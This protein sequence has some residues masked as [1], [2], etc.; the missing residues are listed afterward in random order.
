LALGAIGVVFGDIGT[1]PLYA[2]RATLSFSATPSAEETVLG[3]LSIIIWGLLLIVGGKYISLLLRADNGGEGGLFALLAL[4]RSRDDTP[5]QG[6]GRWLLWLA[7]LG[8]ALLYGDGIITPA[9]SVLSAMGG[10]APVHGPEHAHW[11]VVASAFIV[12]GVFL[13]QRL[14]SGRIGWLVGP[15]ML[16]WFVLIAALGVR[17]I[18]DAPGVLRAFSPVW[19]VQLV[20]SSPGTAFA[21]LGGVV[22]CLTGAEALY[23]DMGHFGR[24]AIAVAWWC[25]VCPSLLLAYLGQGAVI[26]SANKLVGNP[27][28]ELVPPTMLV[29]MVVAATLAAIIAS[30][31]II[32]GVFSMTRQLA[33]QGL[34][35]PLRVIHTSDVEG[36]IY[37]PA[38]NVLMAVACVL[39]VLLFG[40]AE[41]L[42]GAYGLAVTGVMAVS[43]VLFAVVARRR[44]HWPMFAVIPAIVVL[45]SV[46]LLLVAANAL[47]IP[48]GGWMPLAVAVLVLW[49]I[50]VWRAG[51]RRINRNRL[52]DGLPLT[53]FVDSVAKTP[54]WPGTGV[55]FGRDPSTTP[56]T[57]RKLQRHVPTLPETV[58]VVHLQPLGVPRVPFQNRLRVEDLGSGV[59]RATVRFGYLQPPDMPSMLRDASERGVPADPASTSYWV[60]REQVSLAG[61]H[62]GMGRWRL[63]MFAFML[64]NANVLPDMLDLPPRRT[65]EMGMRTS[66]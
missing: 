25:V 46:D 66:L 37:L 34:I 44:W 3:T 40:S 55:F 60:R 19:A 17:A 59:W 56:V 48:E 53:R 27:F 47:K 50:G 23:A 30:Q 7:L 26:L 49:I 57:I 15:L 1:S 39:V 35:P 10:L 16:A 24:R 36:Q 58:V 43:T 11:V 31:A 62:A 2:L 52:E 65:V 51:M 6:R 45:L 5:A 9:I 4:T 14:G 29:P 42:A 33:Q 12:V 54:R 8:A 20:G 32:S 38:I 21:M 22:L 41:R 28:F 13:T 18:L 61:T 63:A 64:R